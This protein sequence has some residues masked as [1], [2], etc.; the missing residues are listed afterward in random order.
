[1]ETSNHYA[2]L[3][4]PGSL[5]FR[6]EVLSSLPSRPD[7]IR[8]KVYYCGICGS[9][10]SFYRG[11]P[12]VEYPRTLGHEYYGQVVIPS[13]ECDRIQSGD[14][15]VVD[16]NYRCGE[17]TFCR[18]GRSNLCVS[19][20]VNLFTRRG[21]SNYVDI[22]YSYLHRLPEMPS[23]LL[24]ALVEPLSCVL[25][26]LERAQIRPEDE[27]LILGCGG[28]GSLI[29]T[30]LSVRFPDLKVTL[31]DP[32][33][34]KA[35][36]L[37]L[38]FPAQVNYLLNLPDHNEYS[39]IFEVSGESLG[40]DIAATSVGRGGRI[41]ICSR[42]RESK[43]YLHEELSQKEATLLFS[44]LNGDGGQ[45]QNAINLLSKYWDDRWSSLYK[46][47]SFQNLDR[48]FENI[49]KSE[50]CKTFVRIAEDP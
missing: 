14:M 20:S 26:A 1:M 9:D 2:W 42:Y 34:A 11:R 18:S 22:H 6:S 17:C 15:V 44:H 7:F 10:I 24:G 23:P 48:I 8:M 13:E 4:R 32:N 3:L 35:K 16:P 31:Y 5:E 27:I 21:F 45:F 38:V 25:H 50:F 43:A 41:V 47:E 46:I 12:K 36:R 40:F 28:L 29:T 37:A 33:L 39:L 30:V 19:N 49:E